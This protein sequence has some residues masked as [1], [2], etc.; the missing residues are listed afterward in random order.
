MILATETSTGV[1]SNLTAA[2]PVGGERQE[3]QAQ[4][5]CRPLNGYEL[6][7]SGDALRVRHVKLLGILHS[8]GSYPP[9]TRAA[10]T[11]PPESPE[12]E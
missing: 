12:Y 11:A 10:S 4:W 9:A 3:T 2:S 6:Q 1:C 8:N 7:N 5:G